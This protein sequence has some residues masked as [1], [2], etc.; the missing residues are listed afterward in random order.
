MIAPRP[1]NNGTKRR[2]TAEN[3]RFL[4][5]W[6]VGAEVGVNATNSSVNPAYY[7]APIYVPPGGL[8]RKRKPRPI[9]DECLAKD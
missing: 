5:F 8:L 1:P 7:D 3:E 9:H 4:R 6:T 2:K